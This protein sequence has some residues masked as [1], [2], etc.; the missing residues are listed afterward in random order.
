MGTISRIVHLTHRRVWHHSP[1]ARLPL[2]HA[3]PRSR[4]HLASHRA[5]V[6]AAALDYG[7]GM[8]PSDYNI[9]EGHTVGNVLDGGRKLAILGLPWDTS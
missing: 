5:R 9:L 6:M 2:P 1:N 7:G 3:R 8:N 4:N